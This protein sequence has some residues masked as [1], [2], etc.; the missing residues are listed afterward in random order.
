MG[1]LH[2]G[3]PPHFSNAVANNLTSTFQNGRVDHDDLVQWPPH[4]PDLKSFEFLHV[5][6]TKTKI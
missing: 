1:F 2:N 5:G 4:S 6:H 3:V